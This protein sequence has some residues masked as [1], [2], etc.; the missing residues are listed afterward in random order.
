MEAEFDFIAAQ[1]WKQTVGR[2]APPLRSFLSYEGFYNW[3]ERRFGLKL[4]DPFITFCYF[5]NEK[6]SADNFMNVIEQKVISKRLSQ[7]IENKFDLITQ[8]VGSFEKLAQGL[9]ETSKKL[10][11]NG[12]LI[13]KRFEL[14]CDAWRNFAP[15]YIA[16]I[17]LENICENAVI[18]NYENKEEMRT[19]L[20]TLVSSNVKSEFFNVTTSVHA[21]NPFSME[22]QKYIDLLKKLSQT[23]DFRKNAY[24]TAWYE[25]STPFFKELE[26]ATHLGEYVQWVSPEEIK[27][28]L[29]AHNLKSDF[30]KQCLVYSLQG[31][32]KIAYSEDFL[33]LRDKILNIKPHISEISGSIAFKGKAIGMVKV[34]MPNDPKRI[35]LGEIL[36]TKMTTPD[37]VP[38]MSK[39]A[40][41]VTDEGGVTSHA[42]II[43][44]EFKKP[45]IVGTQYATKIL[46]TGDMV[47]VDAEKGIVKKLAH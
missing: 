6:I 31:K 42:A 11:E 41:I 8:D 22:S 21:K 33:S 39:C 3:F 47:E 12:L 25:L 46:K 32:A 14:F 40:A 44:R 1:E 43:S 26:V 45:C 15:A 37:F 17:F 34:I 35:N 38:L 20:M 24:E 9:L 28:R 30:G 29:G 36:V 2:K 18:A 5:E 4:Q 10:N 27:K 13:A 16:P 23:R 19:K 7:E